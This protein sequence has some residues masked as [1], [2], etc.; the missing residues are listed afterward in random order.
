MAEGHV[1]YYILFA[2]YEQGLRL[3]DLLDGEIQPTSAPDDDDGAYVQAGPA[4]DGSSALSP[5]GQALQNALSGLAEDANKTDLLYEDVLTE[6]YHYLTAEEY[7]QAMDAF[8]AFVQD[9]LGETYDHYSAMA[10]FTLD[11]I[12]SGRAKIG[13]PDL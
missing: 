13:V 5:E 6:G 4:D 7:T 9:E 3:H 8:L 12:R 1:R 11:A 10:Q 2:N